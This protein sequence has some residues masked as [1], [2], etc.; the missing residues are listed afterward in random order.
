[1]EKLWYLD[2]FLSTLLA[3][4]DKVQIKDLIVIIQYTSEPCITLPSYPGDIYQC[5]ETLRCHN[6][7]GV[8]VAVPHKYLVSCWQRT[9]L[10]L[11]CYSE[12]GSPLKRPMAPI[13]I[14]PQTLTAPNFKDSMA[15]FSV[16]IIKY[17]DKYNSKEKGFIW[18]HSSRLQF[19]MVGKTWKHTGKASGQ[20][21]ETGW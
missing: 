14:Q 6:G 7:V 9:E 4:T 10:F 1:M 19:I 18:A 11:T 12:Q 2:C 20:K 8:G 15:Y 16:T 17:L 3:S 13:I 21:Q 5:L